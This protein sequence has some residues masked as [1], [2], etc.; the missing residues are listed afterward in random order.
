LEE[1]GSS[2]L[3]PQA[4]IPSA[5]AHDKSANENQREI[6]LLTLGFSQESITT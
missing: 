3:F 6:V 2:G 4:A 1:A 5:T